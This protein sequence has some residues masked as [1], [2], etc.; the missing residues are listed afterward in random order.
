MINEIIHSFDLW[1]TAQAIKTSGRGRSAANQSLHGINKLRELIISLAIQGKLVPQKPD[2]EAAFVVLKKIISKKEQLLKK[3]IIK[4][5][6]PLPKIREDEKPFELPGS[7]AWVR[8]GEVTNYGLIEKVEPGEV[9]EN[10]WILELE[11]IE[12]ETSKL[13]QKIRVCDKPF[14]S[15]KNRFYKGDVIY[16][17]LRPYLDKVIV[18]DEDGICTTE[19]IPLKGYDSITP[20]FLR[21]VMKSS[22]FIHYASESTHGMNLPRLGTEKARLALFPI[23]N[24]TLVNRVHNID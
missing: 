9:P 1:T 5:Q 21:I 4:S 17:K 19:M 8:L 13:L 14:Q 12:K 7:W 15:S 22:Y 20:D 3:G 11:D 16:G 10:T 18:A 23:V 24:S 6:S 2:D